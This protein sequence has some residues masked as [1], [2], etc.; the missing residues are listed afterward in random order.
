VVPDGNV[1]EQL[2]PQLMPAGELLTV[3]VPV[4]DRL[5]DTANTG[6]N[7]AVTAVFEFREM[8]HVPIPAQGDPLQPANTE[9]AAA[10]GVRVIAVPESNNVEQAVPQLI[11]AGALTILPAPV[12]A[13]VSESVNCGVGG[14]PKLATTV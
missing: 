14:G 5:T 8:L 12:P 9:P 11:P 4:P 2:A 1:A 10:I 13:F 6:T 3:P 7:V